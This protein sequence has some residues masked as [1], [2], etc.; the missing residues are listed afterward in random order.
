MSVLRELVS[1]FFM[2]LYVCKFLFY[3]IF[4]VWR[5]KERDYKNRRESEEKSNRMNG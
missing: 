4:L 1:K 5:E 3:F 2:G